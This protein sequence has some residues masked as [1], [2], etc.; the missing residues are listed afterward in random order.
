MTKLPQVKPKEVIKALKRLGFE[1]IRTTGSHVRLKDS[2]GNFVTVAFHNR[3]LAKG[4]IKSILRQA[5]I[6]AEQ[7]LENL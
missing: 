7:L 1:H 5:D 2:K 4:T 3:T 6:T